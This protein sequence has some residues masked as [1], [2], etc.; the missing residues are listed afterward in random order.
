MSR[1]RARRSLGLPE[2]GRLALFVSDPA[3]VEKRYELADMAIEQV[4][5]HGHGIETAE[6]LECS[7]IARAL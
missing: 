2:K 5:A 3:R 1:V 4:R 7:R 6:A